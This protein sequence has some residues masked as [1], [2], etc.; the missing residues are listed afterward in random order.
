MATRDARLCQSSPAGPDHLRWDGI[1]NTPARD[2][3]DRL[4]SPLEP[5]CPGV[6]KWPSSRSFY[7]TGQGFAPQISAAYWAMVR[8]LENFPEPATFKIA[9]R[10]HASSSAYSSHSL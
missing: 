3:R 7:G 2:G 10:A 9:F 1:R 5:V 6:G 8:S 4:A